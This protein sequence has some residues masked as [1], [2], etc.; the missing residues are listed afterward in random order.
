[1]DS[2]TRGILWRALAFTLV[3]ELLLVPAVLFWPSFRDNITALQAMMPFKAARAMLDQ[4]A[5]SGAAGYICGQQF[6]KACNTLGIAAAVLFAAGAVAGEA[7]RGTLELWLSRPVSR[8]RILLERWLGGALAVVLP[9]FLTTATI[10]WLATFVDTKL[11]LYP[12]LLCAAHESCLLLAFYSATF[13]CSTVGSNP[14]GIGFG[15]LLFAIFQ[16]AIYLVEKITHYSIFRLVD[17]PH[18]VQICNRASLDLRLV[19]PMLLVSIVFVVAS[20][21]A[22]ERRVP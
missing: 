1:M 20:L 13:F 3:L 9:V 19:A 21:I 4:F 8:K 16:F 18:F 15:M 11:D 22:F 2:S 6:F 14:L 12:L 7:H 17:I 5:G 10:P